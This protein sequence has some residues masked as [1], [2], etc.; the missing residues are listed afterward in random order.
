MDSDTFIGL[1][2][3][4]GLKL[5]HL[6]IRSLHGKIDQLRI[7][8]EG[9]GVDIV[10]LSETWVKGF[11]DSQLLSLKGYTMLRQD[12]NLERV[13]KKNGGGLMTYIRTSKFPDYKL[14]D[15]LSTSCPHIEAQWIEI[16]RPECKN[17][18]ICNFYR[19]PNT[20]LDKT[21]KYL[22]KCLKSLN[23]SKVDL[24]LLGDM[25]I[26]YLKKASPAYI[27]LAFFEKSNQ[28]AQIISDTTRN[29]NNTKTLLDIIL[30]DDKHVANSGTL[31][32]M[33]SDH[34]SIFVIKKK[35][36]EKRE[37]AHFVG[38]S[39]KDFDI[40]S[41]KERL[42]ALDLDDIF[43]I[44]DPEEIWGNILGHIKED[45]DMHCPIREFNIRNYK[46]EWVTPA[47]LEQI[48]DRDY[49]YKKAKQNKSED[50]WNIAKHLRNLANRNITKAKADF[51]INKL[52]RYKGDSG[53]SG[54]KS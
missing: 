39:Y 25:N 28:L 21:L 3:E 10:T 32:M 35:S 7:A 33:M 37:E 1:G 15:K 12:R 27:K 34:Q 30:T 22:N 48:R 16:V 41:F 40:H 23:R 43:E 24:Y 5:V 14:L 50:D 8:V 17:L 11:L 52:N 44:D 53:N 31:D 9:S 18:V 2:K 38:R 36:R 47:L 49:F 26:D 13:G 45:L 19:L 20:N 42:C 4:K 54:K 51:V 6:N 46:P 29:T